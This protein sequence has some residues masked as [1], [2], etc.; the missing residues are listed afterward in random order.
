MFNLKA[1]QQNDPWVVLFNY[2]AY[3]YVAYNNINAIPKVNKYWQQIITIVVG[4]LV[5]EPIVIVPHPI[6]T[7][8]FAQ[9]DY[10]NSLYICT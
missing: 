4:T 6:S 8:I 3:N 1:V 9:D 2:C 10:Y 5:L 7:Y